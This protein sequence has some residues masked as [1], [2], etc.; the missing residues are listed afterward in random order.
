LKSF[1]QEVHMP[2]YE[3]TITCVVPAGIH[4]PERRVTEDVVPFVADNDAAAMKIYLKEQQELIDFMDALK[5]D[6]EAWR[7]TNGLVRVSPERKVLVES[8]H[9]T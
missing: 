9:I 2:K 5:S 8:K 6:A 1:T 7:G 3:F 4:E